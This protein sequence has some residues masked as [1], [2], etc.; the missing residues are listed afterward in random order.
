MQKQYF[1]NAKAR[2]VLPKSRIGGN[3][4]I[5]HSKLKLE[6]S[7]VFLKSNY[8]DRLVETWG[9]RVVCKKWHEIQMFRD[10]LY[11]I[12]KIH[13]SMFSKFDAKNYASSLLVCIPP[14]R[15]IISFH[16]HTYAIFFLTL[17]RL[18]SERPCQDWEGAPE[19]PPLLSWLWSKFLLKNHVSL[20]A[21]TN[22]NSFGPFLEIIFK[23]R[24]KNRGKLKIHQKMAKYERN[25]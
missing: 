16:N 1:W 8:L 7:W 14:S 24:Q 19:A 21:G 9:Q 25:F 20:K 13:C 23:N 10:V 4:M 18:T 6:H 3:T 11:L 5:Y 22:S 12:W 15:E 2:L 17:I